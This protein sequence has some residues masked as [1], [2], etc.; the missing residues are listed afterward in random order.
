MSLQV[1]TFVNGRWRQN[2]HLIADRQKDVLIVDPGS[3]SPGL[4]K[5]INENGWHPRA[6]IN[7]HGHFDHIGAVAD[8]MDRYAVPFYLH[9]ADEALLRRGQPVPSSL[10]ASR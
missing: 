1:S 3:D 9:R 6:I 8:L 7:T 2:C 4:A 5:L 10:R